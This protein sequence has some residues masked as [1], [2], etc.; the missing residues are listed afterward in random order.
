MCG[1][2]RENGNISGSGQIRCKIYNQL[3]QNILSNKMLIYVHKRLPS[4]MLGG[5]GKITAEL[6]PSGHRHT[7]RGLL[8]PYLVLSVSELPLPQTLDLD[9][10]D[11]LSLW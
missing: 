4:V 3:R 9:L 1:G 7:Y 8:L 10:C 2:E 11:V 5:R 6:D